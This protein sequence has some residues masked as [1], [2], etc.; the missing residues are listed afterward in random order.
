LNDKNLA[1][2]H[3]N[4]PCSFISAAVARQGDQIW[5]NFAHCAIVYFGQFFFFY[6]GLGPNFWATFFRGKNYLYVVANNGLG[7]IL[8]TNSSG[9]P[10]ARTCERT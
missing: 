7:Y 6:S 4:L 2:L 5:A 3:M 8:G 10:V 1:A 9:H